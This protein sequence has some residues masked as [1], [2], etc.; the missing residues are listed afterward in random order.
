MMKTFLLSKCSLIVLLGLFTSITLLAQNRTAPRA[1]YGFAVIKGHVK[2]NTDDF[3]EFAQTGYFNNDVVSVHVD[4][5]GD[6][7]KKIKLE[8]DAQDLYLYLNNDAITIYVQKG[9]TIE[10]NWD[11]KDFNKSFSVKSGN[12]DRNGDL[13]MMLTLYNLYRRESTDLQDSLYKAHLSDSIKFSR[14]N[15]LYNKE[16]ETALA[17]GVHPG[18]GKITTD[19]YFEFTE[20]LFFQHLLPGY[21]LFLQ[22]PSD[23]SRTMPWLNGQKRYQV[24]SLKAFESSSNYRDF[25]FNYVRFYNPPGKLVRMVNEPVSENESVPFSACWMDY[26]AGLINFKIYTVRDWFIT[27]SIM[28]DFEFYPFDEASAVYN[29]FMTKVRVPYYADTIKA[30]YAN[31]RRLKPGNPAPVFTLNDENGRPVSL[32]DLRGKVVYIDFW[33]VGCGPCVYDI[34]NNVPALHERYKGRNI[35]FLN[36]CVDTN[37][38]DWKENLEKLQL[39]GTNLIAQG[40]VSNPVCKAYGINGIPHYYIIDAFGKI[41]DNNSPRPSDERLNSM[42]D[43]L[44]AK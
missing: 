29:D 13:Q 19:I 23:V 4:Q 27:K 9:D 5:D 37:E 32:T 16:I 3:W 15:E 11:A 20:L 34:K 31:V 10:I 41:V 1:E 12:P 25:E 35:V 2:N 17:E 26:Y 44:L 24:E 38:K 22:H 28:F 36:I 42:L 33:G 8:G 14:I 7:V 40:W 39:K 6:F 43:K 18:T 30:F 21:D